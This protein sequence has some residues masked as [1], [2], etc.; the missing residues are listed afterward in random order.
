VRWLRRRPLH[1]RLA[2]KGGL[3]AGERPP[4]DTTPR[5]GEVGIH[6]VPRPRRWD[7]VASAE[8]PEL[9]AVELEFVALPDGTLLLDEG[10][11]AAGVEPLAEAIERSLP[12]PYRGEAVRRGEKTWAV[13]ARAIEV[14]ELPDDVSGEEITLTARGG[15]RTLV[16]DGERLFGSVPALERLAA[17]RFPE[18]YVLE[19][20]RLDETLWEVR[21]SAL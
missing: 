7:A 21:I 16:V 3:V 18:G 9:D 11:P 17:D 8:A 4:V 13:A 19:A 15:E 14:A 2:E 5:W 6:G 12:P 10:V 20:K 1:E